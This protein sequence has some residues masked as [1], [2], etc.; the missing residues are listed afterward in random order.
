MK[1]MLVL[2]CFMG[3]IYG[4]CQNI[5]VGYLITEN[6]EFDPDSMIVKRYETLDIEPGIPNPDWEYYIEIGEDPNNAGDGD[7]IPPRLNCGEDYYRFMSNAP[8]MTPPIQ[9]IEGTKP[10]F[11]SLKA[12]KSKDGNAEKLW[13]NLKVYGDGSF[14]IPLKHEIPVGRYLISLTFTNEGYSKDVDDCFTIIVK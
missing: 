1:N 13:Q 4:S 6:A 7:P 5:T 14:E 9:G 2:L 11:C 3:F 12:I 10:I 8:W